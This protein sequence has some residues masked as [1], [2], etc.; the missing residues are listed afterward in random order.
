M[1]KEE[2]SNEILSNPI[3]LRESYILNNHTNLYNDVLDYINVHLPDLPT[4]VT[5][6]EKL[7]YY[8]NGEINEKMCKI[9]SS[10]VSFNKKFTDGY[11]EYCSARCSQQNPETK[12][13]RKNTIIEIYGVDN[14]AKLDISKV[15]AELTN[16][17]RYGCKSSFQNEEVREKWRKN[18]REKY[19][20]EHTFQLEEVKEKSKKTI[21][22]KYEVEHYVQSDEYKDKLIEMGHCEYMKDVYH[23]KTIRTNTRKYGV[24]HYIQSIDFIRKKDVFLKKHGIEH[25]NQLDTKIK[26]TKLGQKRRLNLKYNSM[27]FELIQMEDDF[28]T[29]KDLNS[30]N[31]IF[32]INKQVFRKR[33]SL[34]SSGVIVCTKCNEIQTNVSYMEKELYNYLTNFIEPKDIITSDRKILSGLELD[35]YIPRLK[36]AFEFNGLY[37]HSE[38]KKPKNSHLCKTEICEEDNISL[39]HIWEDDWLYK[40]DMIKSI[41]KNKLG[42]TDNKIYARKCFIKKVDSKTSRIFLKSNH[43]QGDSNSKVKLGLYHNDILVSLM[44][45]GDRFINGKKETELIRFCNILDTCV[46][47]SASKLFKYFINNYD[48]GIIKS[49]ADVS[50][51]SGDL[52]KILGFDYIHR[53]TLNYFWVVDNLRKHRFN[54]TKGK[55][56]KQG[57]DSTKTEVEIMYERGYYRIWGCGYDLYIFK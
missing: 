37:W 12:L 15:K 18:I 5:F 46:I 36:L 21:L 35:I 52:Y 53:S 57:F 32:K 51:F 39:L 13:K 44:T 10:K 56:V 19:G 22:E 33:V 45:F 7:W 3:R 8:F 40:T 17:E 55:L 28:V 34:S 1:S 30:C 49:Y 9:C 38:L 31:H 47:G 2:I 48:V 4:E 26:K 27:G 23:S 41:I 14:I 11:K 25:I 29:L 42:I 43:L 20:V 16:L 50:M 6:K 54:Y 24:A